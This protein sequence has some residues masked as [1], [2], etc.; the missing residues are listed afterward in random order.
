LYEAFGAS[1]S[2]ADRVVITDIY[3]AGEEPVPGVTGKLISDAVCVSLPGRSVVYLPH[4]ADVLTY[5]GSAVRSGD[6]VLTLGA[7]DVT[8]LGDE[9]LLR[10]D[11]GS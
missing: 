11:D 4:R 5:L 7:G 3:G 2:D 9:L 10:L 1:F 6:L 8:S